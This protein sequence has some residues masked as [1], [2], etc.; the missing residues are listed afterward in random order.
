MCAEYVDL[1][2][3]KFFDEAKCTVK[4]AQ[5]LGTEHEELYITEED[6]LDLV[7]SLPTYYDEPFADSA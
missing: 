6:M 4:I 1:S 2:H 7:E 3:P 5:Y